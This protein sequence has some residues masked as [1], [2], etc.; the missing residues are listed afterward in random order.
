MGSEQRGVVTAV[1]LVGSLEGSIPE[2]VWMLPQLVVLSMAGNGFSGHIGTTATMPSLIS[3][4]LSH[5]Y[6]TGVIPS[7]LQE[8]EG[9]SLLDL[10]H[11]KLTGDMHRFGQRVGPSNGTLIL[12]VNRLSGRLAAYLNTDYSNL[13]ILSGNLFSCLSLPSHDKNWQSYTCG[14]KEYDQAM[15]LLGGVLAVLLFLLLTASLCLVVPY[16]NTHI[17]PS[18]RHLCSDTGLWFER[19]LGDLLALRRY[20]KYCSSHRPSSAQREGTADRLVA[21]SALLSSLSRCTCALVLLSVVLSLPIYLLKGLDADSAQAS[22]DDRGEYV[23]HTHLYRWLW[24]MA[25][26]SGWVPAILFLASAGVICLSLLW[27]IH[28]LGETPTVKLSNT[29]QA[30]V[31]DRAL[32]LVVWSIFVLNIAV[33]GAVNGLYLWSTLIDLSA[34]QRMSIQFAFGFFSLLWGGTLLRAALPTHMERSKYGVWL[35]ACLSVVNQV[36]IPC[37][38]TALSTPSCYQV[39]HSA[40]PFPSP[41]SPSSETLGP[42]RRYH[43]FVHL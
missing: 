29:L 31:N 32:L 5:N 12:S 13:D 2:C 19:R 39:G 21:F 11:N 22:D 43:R 30:P 6:L 9:M 3:L 26:I 24:T 41:V 42:S 23:T 35:S 18:G 38:T 33:V 15:E 25:F 4:T 1:S 10:S 17:F 14:S 28:L 16:V 7:W 40:L 36:A 8:K 27:A 37:L 20:L 34:S